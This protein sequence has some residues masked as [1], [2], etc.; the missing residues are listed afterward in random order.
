MAELRLVA[1]PLSSSMGARNGSCCT[2]TKARWPAGPLSH[3]S[4]LAPQSR[5]AGEAAATINDKAIPDVDLVQIRL[6]LAKLFNPELFERATT[7]PNRLL[8][9]VLP[10]AMLPR[11]IRTMAVAVYANEVTCLLRVRADLVSAFTTTQV[12]CGVIL[13]EHTAK[14]D[15]AAPGAEPRPQWV[16]R[17]PGT[18]ANEYWRLVAAIAAETNGKICYRSGGTNCLGIRGGSAGKAQGVAAPRW[19]ATGAPEFWAGSDVEQWLADR[20]FS[21]VTGIARCAR[22]AW[23]FRAWPPEGITM[24]KSTSFASGLILAP[25]LFAPSTRK[26]K[27]AATAPP[28]WGAAPSPPDPKDGAGASKGFVKG[29]DLVTGEKWNAA[30]AASAPPAA[31]SSEADAIKLTFVTIPNERKCD[32]AFLAIGQALA[33]DNGDD[34]HAESLRAGGSMQNSLRRK[35]G[36]EVINN[37]E[38][39]VISDGTHQS[40]ATALMVPGSYANGTSLLALAQCLNTELRIWAYGNVAAGGQ[41]ERLQY[42][43]YAI[44][45]LPAARKSRN[46]PRMQI[47]MHLKD[48]HYEF[49]KPVLVPPGHWDSIAVPWTPESTVASQATSDL[50][51]SA[52]KKPRTEGHEGISVNDADVDIGGTDPLEGGGRSVVSTAPTDSVL[53]RW[54]GNQPATTHHPTTTPSIRRPQGVRTKTKST[55][56]S[57]VAGKSWNNAEGVDLPREHR[58]HLHCPCGWRPTKGVAE[59]IAITEARRHWHTCQGCPPPRAKVGQ[60][61]LSTL[62]RQ[63]GAHHRRCLP[64]SGPP[65]TPG[66]DRESASADHQCALF[67]RARGRLPQRNAQ[68]VRV[69]PL[70]PA[71]WPGGVPKNSMSSASRWWRLPHHQ[72][73]PRAPRAWGKSRCDCP[74]QGQDQP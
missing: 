72:E 28:R 12:P 38:R 22:K 51:T 58:A 29:S 21:A 32:C 14:G 43:L 37:P 17:A 57:T 9:I 19:T 66:L 53:R 63:V 23:S 5:T 69:H 47:W 35:A 74:V 25:A 34:L 42:T 64:Q 2:P 20:H 24:A 70:Q 52:T 15:R 7:H 62:C 4:A 31:A 40:F 48:M 59:N 41:P 11:I 6:T 73:S 54:L 16:D 60:A 26:G 33:N 45:P 49:L 67:A 13:S 1:L 3:V 55:C 65:G 8:S 71:N 50:C 61:Q 46:A 39:Y 56:R 18:S 36:T 30:P 68:R 44:R 10:P 27:V